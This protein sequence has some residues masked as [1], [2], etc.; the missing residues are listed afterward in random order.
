R[1]GRVA[2][3]ELEELSHPQV[4][5]HVAYGTLQKGTLPEDHFLKTGC[6]PIGAARQLPVHFEVVLAL[7]VKRVQSGQIRTG[8]IDRGWWGGPGMVVPRVPQE[9]GGG[10]SRHRRPLV[11]RWESVTDTW[12]L[13][14][15]GKVVNRV[16]EPIR[17]NQ[18]DARSDSWCEERIGPETAHPGC[19]LLM[20]IMRGMGK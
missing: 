17:K 19:I 6:G 1:R 9:S 18:G 4:L 2:R 15:V 14:L 7:E 8:Q 10:E 20:S 13:F 5:G 12:I 16:T 3:P 11:V